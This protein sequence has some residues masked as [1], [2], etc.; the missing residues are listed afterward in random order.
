MSFHSC[1]SLKSFVH[2]QQVPG[3]T[4]TSRPR[5][6]VGKGQLGKIVALEEVPS[7]LFKQWLASLAGAGWG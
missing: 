5:Q 3:S 6:Q 1:E 2:Q 4:V 7:T